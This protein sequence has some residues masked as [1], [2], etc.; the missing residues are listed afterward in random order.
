MRCKVSTCN[1]TART[2]QQGKCWK[3]FGFCPRHMVQYFPEFYKKKY[4]PENMPF[5]KR[6]RTR[7][8][9][10]KKTIPRVYRYKE[11]SGLLQEKKKVH[12]EKME[13]I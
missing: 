3:E 9:E 13:K 1:E 6:T 12:H 4:N 10:I 8:P 2:T 11:I 7:S 5:P